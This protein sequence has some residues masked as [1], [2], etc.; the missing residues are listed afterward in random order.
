[1][2]TVMIVDDCESFRQQIKRGVRAIGKKRNGN[3]VRIAAETDSAEEAL[4]FLRSN[5][6]DILF[7]AVGMKGMKGTDGLELTEICKA[8]ELC[9]CVVLTSQTADFEAARR[10]ILM[11]AF[12]FMVKPVEEEQL[13][14]VL[15]RAYGFL[16]TCGKG[17]RPVGEGNFH[18]LLAEIKRV[19]KEY[20]W[21]TYV[22]ENGQGME[23]QIVQGE[24][25]LSCMSDCRTYLGRMQ[26]KVEQY[27]PRGISAVSGTAARHILCHPYERVTLTELSGICCVCNTYLSHLFKLEMKQSL[28]DYVMMYKMDILK[29]LLC[30][31]DR[32]LTEL[33]DML[34][35]SDYKYMGRI[36]KK[37]YG[38][39]PTEYR[40]R[41]A[42]ERG[43]SRKKKNGGFGL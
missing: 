33:A 21:L 41:K 17:N 5:P 9:R 32:Y 1:M 43:G 19:K 31:T 27:Y 18:F 25:A 36:F 37:Q 7:A 4:A 15:E 23:N 40:K 11:G 26:D 30:E 24:P 6:V 34:G 29:N 2:W 3:A 8:E 35:Y 22:M 14:A 13:R 42:G 12:D 28:M 16:G 38:F 20:P 39:S 10:G